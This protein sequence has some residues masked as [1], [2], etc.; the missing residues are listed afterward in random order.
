MTIH[1]MK[2]TADATA[3]A[4]AALKQEVVDRNLNEILREIGRVSER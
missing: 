2:N 1:P 4:Y 3:R